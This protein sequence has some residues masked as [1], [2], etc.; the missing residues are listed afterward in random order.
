MCKHS[1]LI[2]RDG[3]AIQSWQRYYGTDFDCYYLIVI[4]LYWCHGCASRAT[5]NKGNRA[6]T[7]TA[8]AEQ[9]Q[10]SY[11]SHMKKVQKLTGWSGRHIQRKQKA[12][13]HI[14]HRADKSQ[15]SIINTQ[16]PGKQS[17][18]PKIPGDLSTGKK[19]GS[20]NR[21]YKHE[22]ALPRG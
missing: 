6:Q 9:V 20:F 18:E 17:K 16:G 12:G 3:I 11:F 19:A 5:R 8:E 2:W 4:S 21:G 13:R 14:Q 7:Q 22:L 15:K 1:V 10:F